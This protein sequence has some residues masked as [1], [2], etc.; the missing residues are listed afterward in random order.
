VVSNRTVDKMLSTFFKE[1]FLNKIS[2]FTK[3]LKCRKEVRFSSKVMYCTKSFSI[4]SL[5]GCKAEEG[6]ERYDTM[7]IIFLD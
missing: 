5:A 7:V 1:H 3:T 2:E 4:I 6:R